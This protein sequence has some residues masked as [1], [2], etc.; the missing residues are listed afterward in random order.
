MEWSAQTHASSKQQGQE[1]KSPSDA[2]DFPRDPEATTIWEG[3]MLYWVQASCLLPEG[4]DRWRGSS[5][6]PIIVMEHED[7]EDTIPLK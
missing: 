5:L 4:G 2:H 7:S 3:R 6:P 1:L